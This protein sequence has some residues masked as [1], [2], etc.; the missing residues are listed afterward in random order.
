MACLLGHNRAQSPHSL[1]LPN[2]V[3][4][5]AAVG[6]S[7]SQKSSH[8]QFEG[9]KARENLTFKLAHER[10]RGGGDGDDRQTQSD[11]ASECRSVANSRVVVVGESES[12]SQR[13]Q[14]TN[15]GGRA[16]LKSHNRAGLK[17]SKE[18]WLVV[19]GLRIGRLLLVMMRV[20]A[21]DCVCVDWCEL[22]IIRHL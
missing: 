17:Q 16:T 11:S 14:E 6:R 15:G 5:C 12:V 19:C 9:K 21:R 22:I 7:K 18:I 4:R 10:R 20:W 2:R 1:K 13:V 8:F 3:V